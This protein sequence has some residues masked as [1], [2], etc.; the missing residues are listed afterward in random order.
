MNWNIA[1]FKTLFGGTK[2]YCTRGIERWATN[3]K[4]ISTTTTIQATVCKSTEPIQKY[5]EGRLTNAGSNIYR[6]YTPKP[7]SM[8]ANKGVLKVSTRKEVYSPL[9]KTVQGNKDTSAEV[10]IN[11][12]VKELNIDQLRSFL[13]FA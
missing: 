8:L 4:L 13:K 10:L 9:Y 7:N 1:G 3:P 2:N 5:V 6:E 12:E 11:G